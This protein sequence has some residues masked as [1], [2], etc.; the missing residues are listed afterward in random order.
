MKKIRRAAERDIKN[1]LGIKI[2]L[3]LWVKVKEHWRNRSAS[4]RVLGYNTDKI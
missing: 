1:I 2:E 4:L 3:I